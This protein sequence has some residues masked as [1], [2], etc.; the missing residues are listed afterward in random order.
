METNQEQTI[1][2]NNS[3]TKEY[4]PKL[5][6]GFGIFGYLILFSLA[7]GFV[8]SVPK[9]TFGQSELLGSLFD[10][11]AYLAT[12]ISVFFLVFKK[13]DK[14]E[15]WASLNISKVKIGLL[16]MII[17]ISISGSIVIE[18]MVS[19]LPMP[20]F[21]R[22]LFKNMIKT[23]AFSMATVVIAAPILEEFIFRGIILKGFLKNYS[24]SKAI[25]WSAVLFGLVHMNPW[26]FI[27]AT[28]IGLIIGWLYWKSNS[29]IPGIILHFVNNLS[30]S[31]MYFYS[32]NIEGTARDFVNNDNLYFS[33]YLVAILVLVAAYYY[34]KKIYPNP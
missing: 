31:L 13:I 10:F 29:L 8:L 33:V 34:I 27:G 14:T 11:L 25:I 32:S 21:M 6:Q 15:F 26:Q 16:L 30:A 19:W 2:D 20:D 17:P 1:V 18:P 3:V 22:E 28:A 12:F 4:Y 9:F 7:F 24:P 5:S 23:N